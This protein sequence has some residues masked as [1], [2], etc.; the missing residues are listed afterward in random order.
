MHASL[1][2]FFLFPFS[3]PQIFFIIMVLTQ[4][5]IELAS[6]SAVSQIVLICRKPH[7]YFERIKQIEK[8]SLLKIK[9]QAVNSH[10][11]FPIQRCILFQWLPQMQTEI[12]LIYCE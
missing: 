6:I 1:F 5:F 8:L 7:P 3:A 4:V 11:A 10:Y 2:S 9:T 12:I